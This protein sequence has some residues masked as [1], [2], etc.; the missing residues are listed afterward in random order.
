MGKPA[1]R[2]SDNHSCPKTTGKVP[3]VGG[4]IVTGSGTI[5][6]YSKPVSL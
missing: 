6:T 3:H 1:A 4:P 5:L 2:I